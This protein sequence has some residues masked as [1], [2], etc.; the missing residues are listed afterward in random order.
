M[1]GM[2]VGSS[3]MEEFSSNKVK[4]SH[5]K[6]GRTSIFS[7]KDCIFVQRHGNGLP[8]HMIN[9]KANIAALKNEN[10][11]KI[12][13]ISSCGSLRRDI[14]PGSFMIPHDYLDLFNNQTY[15][16]SD[17][18]FTM[19]GLSEELREKIIN[20]AERTLNKIIKEG[21]YFQT[22]GPRFET[23]AEV[24]LLSKFADVVGMTMANEA[25]LCKELGIDYANISVVDNYAN[26]IGK[27]D[28]S[29][30]EKNRKLNKKHMLKLI[31][32]IIED[33]G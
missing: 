19:L 33:L 30:I 18:N 10:I 2:I 27:F 11:T 13:S 12:I 17:M 6:F 24:N 22:K 9:H 31:E 23:K 15:F 29:E 21:V 1:L 32:N 3:F 8:P 14:P 16:D 25:T 4:E 7:W 5:N 26:G 28:N 20:I